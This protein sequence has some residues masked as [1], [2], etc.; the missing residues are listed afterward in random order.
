M[1]RFAKSAR[2]LAGLLLT[3]AAGAAQAAG[4][5]PA[6]RVCMDP[7]NAPFSSKA[8]PPGLYVELAQRIAQLLDRSMEPVWTLSYFGKRS[9]RTTLL[10]GQCDAYIGL[11]ETSGF[12][13]PRLAM[14]RPIAQ[15]GYALVLPKGRA[16][17]GLADL[18]GL[19]VAVQFG[20]PPQS[21]IAE[22]DDITTVTVRETADG[23]RALATGAADVAFI[24]GPVA[25]FIN[26]TSLHDLY[27]IVPVA[28]PNMQWEAAIGFPRKQD[29]LRGLVDAAIAG[30]ADEI[31]ALRDKYGFPSASEAVV[32]L[33]AAEPEAAQPIQQAAILPEA[34]GADAVAAGH[35]L[36][37][38][39]CSHCHGRDAVQAQRNIDLRRLRIR[40]HDHAGEVYTTTVHNGRAEKGMPNWTDVIS[41]DDLEKIKAYLLS[42]QS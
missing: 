9:V 18:K 7:D 21:L 28:G 10:D 11:P 33:T 14:S 24:W 38:T 42:I 35:E 1:P 3:A 32:T 23:M 39:N 34:S 2:L 22:H 25:G 41:D 29:A 26:K 37:N 16:V 17:A 6:L 31:A 4:P 27:R 15:M 8:N 20:T 13:G 40:Y 19:R 12:M 30:S 5:L 36:F